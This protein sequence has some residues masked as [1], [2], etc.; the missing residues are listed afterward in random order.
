[1]YTGIRELTLADEE[2]QK[3]YED[4]SSYGFYKNEYVLIKDSSGVSKD[5]RKWDGEKLIPLRWKQIDNDYFGKIRPLNDE[6]RFLFDMLQD[7]AIIGKLVQG[8]FGSGKTFLSLS[9]ALDS[10]SERKPKYDK[11]CYVRNPIEVKD[12]PNLG[13]LPSDLNAKLLPW[14]MPIV[15]ILGDESIFEE[16]VLRGKI[17]LDHLGFIRGRSFKRT[18][19]YVNEC[20]NISKYHLALLISRIGE[21]SCLIMDGDI[22]QVDK[23]IFSKKSGMASM[24]EALKGNPMFGMVTL[25]KNE[26]SA[27]ASLADV[28]MEA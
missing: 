18:I 28:L 1:L 11:I 2:F 17:V 8:G 6:Q 13:A 20:Q 3:L 9:W 25:K 12:V 26:R 10:I 21:G 23:E 27:F 15:D 5:W 4:G 7:E 19:V 24:S 22:R 14:A 16:Y